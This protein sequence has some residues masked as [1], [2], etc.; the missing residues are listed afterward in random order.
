MKTVYKYPLGEVQLPKGAKILTVS[1]QNGN[2]V[3]WAE[4]DT[5]QVLE[6]RT[7]EVFGTGWEMPTYKE[8]AYI[9]TMFEGAF[10][11]HVYEVLE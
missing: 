1:H 5:E 3:M 6:H 10:V 8:M 7:F 2:F 4:V 9:G 11:W